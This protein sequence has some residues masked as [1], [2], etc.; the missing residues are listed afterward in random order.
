MFVIRLVFIEVLFGIWINGPLK[1][2]LFLLFWTVHLIKFLFVD[3]CFSKHVSKLLTTFFD[4]LVTFIFYLE[5]TRVGAKTPC[6]KGETLPMY[7]NLVSSLGSSCPLEYLPYSSYFTSL[8]L[9]HIIFSICDFI[10][11]I[12]D[13]WLFLLILYEISFR[14]SL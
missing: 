1:L 3:C 5:E 14:K 10:S 9:Y 2:D 11:I 12:R 4:C 6:V 13:V 8:E 7:F